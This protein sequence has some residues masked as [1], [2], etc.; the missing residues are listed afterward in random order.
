[1]NISTM[2]EFISEY[3]ADM[4]NSE[5]VNDFVLKVFTLRSKYDPDKGFRR[6]I[7]T[8]FQAEMMNSDFKFDKIA[9]SN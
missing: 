2:E 4:L 1:M 6:A 3:A 7:N 9:S 5:L 8:A